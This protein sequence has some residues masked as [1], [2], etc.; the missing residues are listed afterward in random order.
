M[1]DLNPGSRPR[2]GILAIGAA[3]VAA[4]LVG[5]LVV[6]L[7]S[8]TA[9]A[10]ELATFSSCDEVAAWGRAST[11]RLELTYGGGDVTVA[12][13]GAEASAAPTSREGAG[14]EAAG[15]P[16]SD[17]GAGTEGGTNVVVEGV[18]EL[19]VVDRLGDD[20]SL[21]TAGT[22][23]AIADLAGAELLA[24]V[25]VPA[26]AQVTYDADAGVAWV[27]GT[28]ADGMGVSVQRVAVGDA[29][30]EPGAT[31]TTSGW[32]VDARRVGDRLHLV[33]AEGFT[34]ADG[35]V[36]PF[37][38]GPVACDEV[39]HPVGPSDPTATLLV[40][41]PVDGDLV[42]EHA[43]EVVGAGQLVHVTTDA[44]YLATPLWEGEAVTA[45]HR[46]DLD[47]LTPTGSGRV[48]GSLLDEFSMSEHDGHLRVAVTEGGGFGVGRP[49]PIEDGPGGDVIV[50][51]GPIN[52]PV[53]DIAGPA[54][55]VAPMP[56]PER[57]GEAL[58]EVVV[59]DTEGDLD[60]IG[61]TA[62]FGHPGE[63]LHGIRFVGDVAYAVTFLQT[64]PFYVVD[65]ADPAAP[66]VA[67]EVELPGFSAYLHP[68]SD[69]LVAGSV[70][71]SAVRPA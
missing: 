41:L 17:A 34:G 67:G 37:A 12:A 57:T 54:A 14:D 39:L 71:A 52:V 28:G 53:D 22:T 20:R 59:L 40:T 44:A 19:D 48:A 31:W 66:R 15:Q 29:T 33:A 32:L 6:A 25:T 24:R 5:C 13:D 64:D 55:D 70:P 9:A 11:D 69:T 42:P 21:V 38:D 62:R 18:D 45:I 50:D 60:V 27:V 8:G 61:R 43:A 3:A 49:I 51:E 36:L 58:N 65:L 7:P 26:G 1:T 23:L 2:R 16:G 47:D 63:T 35:E 46:F 30:L 10:A 68:I 4:T 56:P